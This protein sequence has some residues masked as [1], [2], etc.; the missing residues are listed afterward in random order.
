MKN[1]NISGYLPFHARPVIEA[2]DEALQSETDR[3][4]LMRLK[5]SRTYM[6]DFEKRHPDGVIPRL[7]RKSD[8]DDFAMTCVVLSILQAF[9]VRSPAA[10]D[11]EGM[12]S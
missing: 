12:Q 1:I 6:R 5:H 11:R 8:L 7:L 4:T 10:E 3:V 2:I 9:G